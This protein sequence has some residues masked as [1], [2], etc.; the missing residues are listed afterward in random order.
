MTTGHKLRKINQLNDTCKSKKSKQSWCNR[1]REQLTKR[2]KITQKIDRYIKK[3]KRH[4][5]TKI[6]NYG[7]QYKSW[8][9]IWSGDNC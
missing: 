9:S 6:K 3:F 7:H 1:K 5:R 4:D 2:T 8:L